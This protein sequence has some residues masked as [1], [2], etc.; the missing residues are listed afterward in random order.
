[1][2]IINRAVVYLGFNDPRKHIRGTEN[3]IKF[4]GTAT[5]GRTFF[6]FRG[7]RAEVFRWGRFVAIAIPKN[8]FIAFFYLRH[9]IARIRI[10]HGSPIV[11]GH[12]YLLAAIVSGAPLIFTVHDALGYNKRKSGSRFVGLFN[13][14]ECW[15]YQ[16]A[17]VIHSI[18]HF[19]W[20]EA[21]AQHCYSSKMV[22]I[23]NTTTKVVEGCVDQSSAGSPS[24]PYILVVR[25]IEPRANL[26][27]ILD[28]AERMLSIQPGLIIKIAGKGPL[29]THYQHL[30]AIRGLSNV[31]LLGYV[32]DEE[33]NKLYCGTACVV[34]PALYGEGFGLPLIEAYARG[35]PAIGS[36]VCA[37]PEV[38]A[39]RELLFENNVESL[40]AALSAARL[41]P[42]EEIVE[43]Y[44]RNFEE[45]LILD[46][47]RRLYASLGGCVKHTGSLAEE[48]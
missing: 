1:M 45:S 14:I 8:Y 16:R 19:T 12:S 13:V 7:D 22:I 23:S 48:P 44:R 3:V 36:N 31:E 42:R 33:L 39:R 41:L 21:V 47:Y 30:A 17:K 25:S 29:L 26:D 27:L 34:M 18:S 20:G 32:S 38:I 4:Q 24:V 37:V 10:R 2:T 5:A 43:H 11:H 9:I 46:Q 6:V 28:L 35:I 40:L 15:V